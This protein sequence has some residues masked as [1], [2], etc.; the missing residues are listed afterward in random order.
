MISGQKRTLEM[1]GINFANAKPININ[2][3]ISD[4]GPE[5]HHNSL[6]FESI[7]LWIFFIAQI[8]LQNG[9]LNSDIENQ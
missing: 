6:H 4:T 3:P 8:S 9:K 1:A 2:S 7:E 5:F